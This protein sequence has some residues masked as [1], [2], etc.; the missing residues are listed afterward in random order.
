MEECLSKDEWISVGS[1][2]LKS[3]FECTLAPFF[4]F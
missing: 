1:S 4:F 2:G 3:I